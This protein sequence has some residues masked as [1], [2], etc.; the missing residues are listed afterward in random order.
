[1]PRSEIKCS[2]EVLFWLASPINNLFNS[3]KANHSRGICLDLHTS[4]VIRSGRLPANTQR[5]LCS[6]RF[7][8]D[9]HIQPEHIFCFSGFIIRRGWSRTETMPK[10]ICHHN[11]ALMP[12]LSINFLLQELHALSQV[13]NKAEVISSWMPL[14][15][16]SRAL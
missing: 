12:P 11:S 16:A 9:P 5:K 2:E 7:R 1:M 10:L 4:C 14:K 8:D 13:T 6:M 15:R 3:P